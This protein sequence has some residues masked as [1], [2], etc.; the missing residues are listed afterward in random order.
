[1]RLLQEAGIYVLVILNMRNMNTDTADGYPRWD[2]SYYDLL[3]R[4][5]DAFQGYPNTLGFAV[6][7]DDVYKPGVED[8]SLEKTVLRDMKKYIQSKNY[9]PI[10]VGAIGF[11]SN[12]ASVYEYMTCGSKES[13]ADFYG[14]KNR[15]SNRGPLPYYRISEDYSNSSVPLY[16]Y[17]NSNLQKDQNYSQVQDMYAEP[18]TKVFSGGV[19]LEWFRN[20]ISTQDH[21]RWT[22]SYVAIE[23]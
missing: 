15:F 16:F 14:I 18:V 3:T 23:Y 10:P 7:L 22:N 12:P 1:M 2:Y 13:S 11:S 9:R 4:L 6:D 21:G 8:V 5:V 17:Y 20:P 19:L